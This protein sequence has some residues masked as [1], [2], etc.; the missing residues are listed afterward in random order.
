LVIIDAGVSQYVG[1]VSVGVL[2][3]WEV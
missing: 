3:Q 1:S 2:V